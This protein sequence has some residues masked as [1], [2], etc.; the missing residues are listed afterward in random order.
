MSGFY[1]GV[2]GKAQK[3]KGCYIGVNDVARK[4]KKIYL[5][6][7][8]GLAKEV[9][10]SGKKL[11]EYTVGSTVYLNENGS[12]VEY[13][14]VHQGLPSSMY[15]S[16]C[17]GVWLLRKD[18]YGN[19]KWHSTNENNYKS[20]TLHT[21]LNDGFLNLFDPAVKNAVK[22]VKIPY[23]RNNSS[24]YSGSNGLDTK[25]FILSCYEVG[26]TTSV[27]S[28]MPVEGAKLNYFEVGDTSGG[29]NRQKRIAKLN[30]TSTSWWLRSPVKSNT[31]SVYTVANGGNYSTSTLTT[32]RGIRP[33]LI[34]PNTLTV[35]LE[36][37]IV[38]G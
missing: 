30:G 35:D 13:L 15:D 14:I 20:S 2:D 6:D 22:Q 10:S 1:I 28:D 33:A 24:V 3:T 5:G 16:S 23:S 12:P 18:V 17:N 19:D 11:S 31:T 26:F 32:S 29:T 21:Y 36:T 9:Y 7:E 38:M 27:S 25:V 4:I 8:N 37:N 34:L